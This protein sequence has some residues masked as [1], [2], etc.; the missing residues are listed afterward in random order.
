MRNGLIPV[1]L[2]FLWSVLLAGCSHDPLM[3]DADKGDVQ[4]QYT[5]A[6][7]YKKGD[8]VDQDYAKALAW[9]KKAAEQGST[10]AQNNIGVMYE[11]GEGV[12]QDYVEAYNWFKRA[13]EMGNVEAQHNLGD[14]YCRGHGVPQDY[15]KAVHWYIQAALQGDIESQTE[16][17]QI[18]YEG[19]GVAQD[20]KQAYIWSALAAT[21]NLKEAIK[22][23]DR[24]A[25]ILSKE[26]L[27]EA[28]KQSSIIFEKIKALKQQ[29]PSQ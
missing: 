5:V 9:Y 3:T 11:R 14:L 7:K 2:S 12:A 6:D 10:G 25:G 19:L 13:A 15:V 22:R 29:V 17:S 23:R 26:D 16:L 24:A 20:Y 18:Y 27:L 28:Q 21:N 1:L 4:A 8:G